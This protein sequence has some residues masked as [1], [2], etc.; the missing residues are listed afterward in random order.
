MEFGAVALFVDRA[1]SVDKSFVLTDDTA[2]IVAD[3]CRRLDGI[4][5]AIELASARVK[6]L[7][8]PNLAQRLNERFKILTGGS[9]TALPRQKTLGAL[10]DWSYD[11][12]T[13]QEQLLFNRVAIFAGGFS[14]DA[15]T[16]VCS[17]E[18]LD[19]IDILDRLSSLTDKSLVVA[20]TAGEQERYHLLESTR[21]YALEKLTA[22]GAHEKLAHRHA[23]Y[24]RDQAQAV[25]ERYGTGSTAAWLASVELELD[26]YR[27][28]LEWALK[29]G[30]DLALGGAVAGALQS[31]WSNGGLAVEG[32]Y[33]IGLAQ[34]GL[35]ESAHPQ[36]A[37][38]LWLALG[39]LSSGTRAHDCAQRAIG[40]CQSVDDEKGQVRALGR[41]AFSLFQMGQL[42]EASDVSARALAATRTLGD[43]PGVANSLNFQASIHGARGDVAAA[44]ESYAQALAAY[45]ALGDEAGT[46]LVLANLAELEFADGQVEQAVRLAAE[47]L[48]IDALGASNLAIDHINIAAYRI[49]LEDVDG[50]RRECSRGA[51]LGA[52]NTECILHRD[53]VAAYRATL[54]VAWRSERRGRLMGYVNAQYKE[55]GQEREITERWGYEKLVA[56]LHGELL[57]EAEIEK[58]AAEGAAW[59]EDRAVDEALKV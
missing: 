56:A 47:A 25:D 52:A 44:R 31:L 7:S 53:R 34:A 30:H 27:A 54:G 14:L 29:D 8:I 35:D 58:T 10:I 59:S 23:E 36:V 42:E 39:G 57:S 13:P 33:W 4:P 22:A 21:A 6:V 24:F 51:A 28:V 50:A 3:I 17:G 38:R 32:R 18:D 1:R 16:A 43:K 49:A 48:E 2:P 37:A 40:L 26:N 5:L 15:A 46:A 9:R 19:E 12:L 45:K 11:L 55:L 41:L 20:D